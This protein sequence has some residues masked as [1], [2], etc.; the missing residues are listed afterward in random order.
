M[1]DAGLARTLGRPA[2]QSVSRSCSASSQVTIVLTALYTEC[3]QYEQKDIII[4]L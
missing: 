2:A 4:L 1:E 3:S